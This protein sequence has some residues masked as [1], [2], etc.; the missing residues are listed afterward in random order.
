[1]YTQQNA[2]LEPPKQLPLAARP[3]DESISI[4]SQRAPADKTAPRPPVTTSR[5]T[6]STETATANRQCSAGKARKSAHPRGLA[7]APATHPAFRTRR[8]PRSPCTAESRDSRQVECGTR[9]ARKTSG[10][11]GATRGYPAKC[12]RSKIPTAQKT[13]QRRSTRPSTRSE[14]G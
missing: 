7:V 9:G 10:N 1:M 14:N 3:I 2:T 13:D 8:L 4:E 12:R 5:Q 6:I 11:I